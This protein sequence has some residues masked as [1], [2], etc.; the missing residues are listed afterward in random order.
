M[1]SL[2]F[3]SSDISKRVLSIQSHVVYGYVGN[4]SAVFPL[5]LCG[6]DVD[7]VNSVQF[8]NHTG[9][10]GGITGEVLNGAQLLDLACGLEK[11]N[12]LG[13]MSHLLTG[14]IGSISFLQSVVEVYTK[15]KEK[16]PDLI[17]VCDPVLGDNGKLYVPAELVEVYRTHILGIA[18]ILTP[19]QFECEQLTGRSVKTIEEAIASVLVIHKSGPE[20]VIVTSLELATHK[21]HIVMLASK[22]KTT[23]DGGHDDGDYEMWVLD[24]PHIEGSY[25]GTGDLTAALFLARLFGDANLSTAMQQV[26]ASVSAVIKRTLHTSGPG[27]ELRLVQSKSDIENPVMG[28]FTPTPIATDTIAQIEATL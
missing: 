22:K 2:E 18:T 15:L 4:K 12:L 26:A 7:V 3:A 25:T 8:S 1:S 28:N 13:N 5:Q 6:F 19:N 17:Y 10:A 14:Y 16:N 21:D 27:A 24:I 11:N 20:I 9:Y 23:N